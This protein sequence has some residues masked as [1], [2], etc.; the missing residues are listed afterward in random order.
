MDFKH[1]LTDE[2]IESAKK[3]ETAEELLAFA[4]DEGIEI[5]DEQ[6]EGISGGW[7]K[8]GKEY[9]NECR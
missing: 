6:L 2:Q 7:S 3:L 8:C 4:K 9:E 1:N 5:S